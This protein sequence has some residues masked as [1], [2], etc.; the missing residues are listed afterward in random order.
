MSILPNSY[1][2]FIVRLR[3]PIKIHSWNDPIPYEC[4]D[5]FVIKTYIGIP[6]KTFYNRKL[7]HLTDFCLV[8]LSGPPPF[9]YFNPFSPRLSFLLFILIIIYR[10]VTH[11]RSRLVDSQTYLTFPPTSHL[12]KKDELDLVSK[13]GKDSVTMRVHNPEIW[14]WSWCGDRKDLKVEHL[15]F[16]TLKSWRCQYIRLGS[17]T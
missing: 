5:H 7:S 3:L 15:P 1:S 13:R 8:T 17:T 6:T 12:N 11:V 14:V 4:I 9:R 2:Y 16:S 10:V